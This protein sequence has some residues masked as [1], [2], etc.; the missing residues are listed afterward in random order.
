MKGIFLMR[1]RRLWLLVIIVVCCGI[2]GYAQNTIDQEI[3]SYTTLLPF[4]MPHIQLPVIPNAS[5]NIK[6][7]GAVADGVTLNTKFINDAIHTCAAKGGGTVIIPAGM[8][9]TGPVQLESN[10]N[11]HL[12]TGAMLLFTQSIDEYP[13]FT[14]SKGSTYRRMP[15][16][17]GSNLDNVAITGSGVVNGNGQYWRMVKKEKLTSRQWKDLVASGGVVSA[18][19]KMWWPS[20]DAMNGEQYL[21]DLK[22]QNKK[23]S[24]EDIAVTRE[25]TR[26]VMVEFNNSK[27][28]LLDGITFTN[29]PAWTITPIQCEDVVLRN[30]K[31]ENEWWW[32][33]ADGLDISACHNVLVCN[34]IINAGDD[35]ICLK[36]GSPSKAY[37]NGF[38]CEN[39]VI[40]D[41]TV[42]HG[43]GG[44]TIGSESY[45]GARN[46]FVK[47]L[48]CVGTDVGLRFKSVKGRGGV[49]ENIF[50]DGVQ[51]KDIANE[52]ILFDMTY[53]GD[54]TIDISNKSR[55]PQFHGFDL[56]HIVCDGASNAMAIRGEP[57]VPV[58][59]IKLHDASFITTRS[60]SLRY[61]DGIDISNV[62][63]KYKTGSLLVVKNAQNITLKQI[64]PVLDV[65][66]F[67]HV[68]GAQSKNIQLDKKDVARA[69]QAVEFG[70]DDAPKDAVIIK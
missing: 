11:L 15:M 58:K 3:S 35:A 32:Q 70:D 31:I 1:Y 19:G 45:G 36:P 29:P 53:D 64:S 26:P 67:A 49:I 20:K 10:I 60:F 33:N 44:F 65:D 14:R 4:K 54:A 25:Y 8:W 55:V 38:S 41:C 16:I 7:Y 18:D 37:K 46:V 13:L 61:A 5:V 48:T 42:F 68:E 12:E 57:D 40:A 34:S 30:I 28:L 51:M 56:Q 50:V 6:D 2:S 63:L 62:T 52:A 9:L 47:N 17:S 39:I 27:H 43:H 59:G 69:K 23:P 66:V 21:K 22:K 24:K